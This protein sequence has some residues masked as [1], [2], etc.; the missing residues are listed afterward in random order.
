MIEIKSYVF[1]SIRSFE[2]LAVTGKP[3]RDIFLNF[4]SIFS[5]TVIHK[6]TKRF[7]NFQQPFLFFDEAVPNSNQKPVTSVTVVE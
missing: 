1:Q 6:K 5:I 4:S 7:N 2:K 3:L